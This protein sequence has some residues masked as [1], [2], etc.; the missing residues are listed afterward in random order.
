MDRN[1]L[2]WGAGNVNLETESHF[3][4]AC[5][6][7]LDFWNRNHYRTLINICNPRGIQSAV[8]FDKNLR[9]FTLRSLSCCRV[10]P[11]TNP[12]PHCKVIQIYTNQIKKAW[13][14]DLKLLLLQI[15][16][17]LKI[18]MVKSCLHL[19]V[20]WRVQ[21]WGCLFCQCLSNNK[22][23]LQNLSQFS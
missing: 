14:L 7:V 8:R 2:G 22:T 12:N 20:K 3:D 16:V 6:K 23:H 15:Y 11:K 17:Q 10:H 1:S 18:K 13:G 5:W 9:C 19:C 21:I 4:W